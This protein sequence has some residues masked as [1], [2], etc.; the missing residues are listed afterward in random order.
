[1]SN[2]LKEIIAQSII[3]PYIFA[4]IFVAVMGFYLLHEY[5]YW[6]MGLTIL[7]IIL[8]AVIIAV[9]IFIGSKHGLV[10]ALLGG[11]NNGR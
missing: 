3:N 4:T 9:K 7:V 5:P 1:M 6:F 2:N 10:S 8:I 11:K